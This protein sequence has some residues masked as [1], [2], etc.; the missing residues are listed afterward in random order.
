MEKEY[1]QEMRLCGSG[2]QG[3][4]MAAIILA[5]AAGVE[6]RNSSYPDLA[7]IARRV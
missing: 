3:I 4:I 7:I 6:R 1:R 2:G 5:E